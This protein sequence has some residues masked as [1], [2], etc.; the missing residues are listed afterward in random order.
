MRGDLVVKRWTTDLPKLVFTHVLLIGVPT[1]FYYCLR[2]GGFTLIDV[3]MAIATLFF[4]SSIIIIIE[5]TTAASR[6]FGN[7]AQQQRVATSRRRGDRLKHRLKSALGIS[8]R[9]A[10]PSQRPVPRSTFLVAAYL[11][12]EQD[13]ILETIYHLLET[14]QRPA[15]G[16]EIILTYN[17]PVDL[18]IETD[19]RLIAAAHPELRLLRVEGS[20]S[21]A[22]NLNAAMELITG[23]MVCILDADHHPI[24][25]CFERAWHWLEFDYDVVQ[26]RNIIRNHRQNLLTQNIAV[27][28]ESVYGVSH[29]AKSLLTDTTI[30]GGSNGYWRTPVLQ[31]IRFNPVRLTEDIDASM[32]T[33]LSGHRIVHDRSIVTTELAPVDFNSF[34]FQRKR[35]AQGWLEVSLKYQR[36]VWKSDKLTLWQKAYWT[37]LLYYCVLYSLIALQILPLLLSQ[38]LYQ[39]DAPPA[40]NLYLFI[41]TLVTFS[42]G[43][44]Q[45]LVTLRVSVTRYPL[46]YFAQHAV[47]IFLYT[48]L[49]N[50]IS[51]VGLYDHIHGVNRWVVTPRASQPKPRVRRPVLLPPTG[52][53][54]ENTVKGG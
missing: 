46:W 2:L 16:L 13:I 11:P 17:T 25:D 28:F 50:M 29:Q 21:K 35:W 42:S 45:T 37:Y 43:I 1:I 52:A 40:E 8:G 15:D 26:G 44:Y 22:E 7:Q 49:K 38:Y 23:E 6:R 3:H 51:V 4:F 9:C 14:I 31:K 5:A 39:G 27:E 53:V 36:R 24:S 54:V 12:N 19:L 10:A 41:T 20:H 32:R 18:P 30:F 47:L 33:L 48:I 34:W